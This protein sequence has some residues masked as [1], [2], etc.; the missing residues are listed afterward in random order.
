[1]M[2]LQLFA[3]QPCTNLSVVIIDSRMED[4]AAFGCKS[5]ID[6]CSISGQRAPKKS[7]LRISHV[8]SI[9]QSLFRQRWGA[10]REMSAPA[11]SEP[12]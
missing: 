12:T 5:M 8:L 1:M 11:D 3:S 6:A 2:Q 7:S 9:H 10:G 4:G